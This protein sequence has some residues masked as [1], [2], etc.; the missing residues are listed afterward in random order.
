M[1]RQDIALV[2]TNVVSIL[3]IRGP[4]PRR[5]FYYS[6]LAGKRL[7]I[8]FF[9]VHEVLW[10]IADADLGPRRRAEILTDLRKYEIRYASDAL[11]SA[12]VQLR[13]AFRHQQL[14]LQD[15]FIA[16]SAVALRCPFATDDRRLAESLAVVGATDVIS[17][18]LQATNSH[19]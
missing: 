1:I 9:T 14:S 13:I 19:G 7:V 16:S 2:D 17:R 11:I 5:D 15:L 12:S 6:R 4:S 18:H 10:G 3:A 8:S